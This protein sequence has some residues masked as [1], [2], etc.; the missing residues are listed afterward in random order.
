M[1]VVKKEKNELAL[2][3]K[4]VATIN[5]PYDLV[6]M[7]GVIIATQDNKGLIA[8]M[9]INLNE[10]SNVSRKMNAPQIAETVKL[11]LD[12]YQNLSLQEYQVFFNRIRFGH[13]GQLYDSLDGIK[14]MAFM[15]QFYDEINT[16]YNEKIY[17][18]DYKH[19]VDAESRD[20]E[21][22]NQ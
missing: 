10:F 21:T 9:L 11:L 18:S 4:Q 2:I 7:E 5:T 8:E 3:E 16:A 12:G 20:L 22:W 13:Y 14:I 19:K 15:R 17:E 6:R 1:Q